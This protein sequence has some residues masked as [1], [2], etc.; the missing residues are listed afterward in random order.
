MVADDNRDAADILGGLLSLAGADVR[1]CYDG[2]AA[3]AA[4][5]EFRPDAG[6]FDLHMP[7]MDGCALARVARGLAGIRPLLLVAVS[8]VGDEEA[9]RRTAAAGFDAHLT[10]PA[11]PR[12]LIATLSDFDR[13]FRAKP[14]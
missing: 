1:V 8:G 2:A 11:D 13:S 12:A 4:V 9:V 6:V 14:R 3:A 7:G 10:K 5:A